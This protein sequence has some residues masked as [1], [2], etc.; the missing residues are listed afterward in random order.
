MKK[1]RLGDASF[2][3]VR[4]TEAAGDQGHH[5][6]GATG[7]LQRTESP[8]I[9]ADCIRLFRKMTRDELVM[10]NLLILDCD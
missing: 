3:S 4:P 9:Y 5:G 7:S 1:R 6:A 2:P 8:W 10:R